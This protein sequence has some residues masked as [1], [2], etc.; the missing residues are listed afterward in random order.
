M[1]EEAGTGRLDDR[2][3]LITGASHGMGAAEARQFHSEGARVLLA[4]VLDVEGEALSREL[5]EFSIRVNSVQPGG[6]L[7][8]M[9][10]RALTPRR[11]RRCSPRFPSD[12][13]DAEKV[14]EL[15]IWLASD[16]TSHSTGPEFGGGGTAGFQM[17]H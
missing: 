14:A 13:S 4:A 6:I 15:V 8:P 12:A 10:T 9:V 17:P 2:V 5:S 3:V 11:S 1:T 7:T 16:A